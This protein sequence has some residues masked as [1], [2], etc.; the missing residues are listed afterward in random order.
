MNRWVVILAGGVGSRFWPLS[1]PSLPKQLLPLIT[2]K[3][4]LVDTLARVSAIAPPQRTLVLTNA[5]LADSVRAACPEVPGE[6]V[7]PEPKPAGTAAALTWAAAEIER[8]DGSD[9]VMVCVHADWAIE[10]VQEF[11]K[12]LVAAAEVARENHS[13]VTVGI[14]PSRPDPGLGYIERGAQVS[15]GVSQV[16]RFVEKPEEARAVEMIAEG[17]LW[18]SGIFAWR[19]GDFLNEVRAHTPEVAPALEKITEGEAGLQKFFGAVKSVSV[20]IGVLER[21]DKVQVVAGDFGWDDIGTW[22]ALKRIGK[23][24]ELGNVI[25]GD[26]HAFAA[27]H[28]VV[29]AK[30]QTVVLYGV[31]DLVVVAKDGLTLVT[32]MEKSAKLKDLL[33]ALP[34]KV[35][36]Q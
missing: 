10:N 3:P 25:H 18:N 28:N 9:A 36:E 15:K 1:T 29:H 2:D 8:R 33:D 16:G 20:D 13:L 24:D 4:L 12:T 30:D 26:V 27:T 34:K 5:S 32:T 14:V 17:A 19:V 11:R 6:N 31:S 22:G 21:S 7:I 35:A 23:P